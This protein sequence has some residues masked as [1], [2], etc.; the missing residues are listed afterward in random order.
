MTKDSPSGP[1]GP[2][3][4]TKFVQ[5]TPE[6]TQYLLTLIVEL[7]SQTSYTARQRAYTVPKLVK[8]LK[9]PTSS[10]LAYQD[11][12]YLLE[13]IEDDELVEDLQRRES[14]KQ[15]LLRIQQLQLDR[16]QEIQSIDLQR[17]QR[18]HRRSPKDPS[19]SGS[20]LGNPLDPLESHF[21]QKRTK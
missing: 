6:D 12:D 2:S 18:R 15:T 17:S 9:D 7:D 8:I 14:A 21:N 1:S 19:G 3:G 13:L 11:V 16:F 20:E 4:D 10:R 5:L